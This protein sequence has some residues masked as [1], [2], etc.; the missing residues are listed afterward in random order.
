MDILIVIVLLFRKR[1]KNEYNF[2]SNDR[3]FDDGNNRLDRPYSRRNYIIKGGALTWAFLFALSVRE[4]YMLYYG[5]KSNKNKEE[6]KMMY[7]IIGSI[8]LGLLILVT[9]LSEILVK[10]ILNFMREEEE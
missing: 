2:C 10:R 8:I 7:F 4:I 5:Y 9:F 6:K 3:R 1:G